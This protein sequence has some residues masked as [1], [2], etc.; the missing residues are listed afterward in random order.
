MDNDLGNQRLDERS[1]GL[2]SMAMYN[3][4]PMRIRQ[5]RRVAERRGSRR[6]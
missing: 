6:V 5:L 1:V 2:F 3:A 4:G